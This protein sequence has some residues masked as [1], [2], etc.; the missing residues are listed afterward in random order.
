MKTAEKFKL[1][2]NQRKIKNDIGINE[3][4]RYSHEWTR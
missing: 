2:D 3:K 1:E 4:E